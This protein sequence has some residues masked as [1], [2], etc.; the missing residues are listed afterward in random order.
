MSGHGNILLVVLGTALL[1]LSL[2]LR[3]LGGRD[4]F[5]DTLSGT[6]LALSVIAVAMFVGFAFTR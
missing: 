1:A 2:I 3:K 4:P 6:C 5:M